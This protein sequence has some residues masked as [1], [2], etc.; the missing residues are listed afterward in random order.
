MKQ[1]LSCKSPY[2]VWRSLIWVS[3][4]AMRPRILAYLL[5]ETQSV[6]LL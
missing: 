1:N 3:L 5:Q 2:E 4:A 6:Y